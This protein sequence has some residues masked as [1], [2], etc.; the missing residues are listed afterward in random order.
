VP[1]FC[2]SSNG[3]IQ[4]RITRAASPGALTCHSERI[5]KRKKNKSPPESN[6]DSTDAAVDPVAD[7]ESPDD[8]HGFFHGA[9]EQ[10]QGAGDSK[11]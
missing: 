3:F 4:R 2:G 5:L 8:F 9:E 11:S 7:I 6:A 10:E 1:V